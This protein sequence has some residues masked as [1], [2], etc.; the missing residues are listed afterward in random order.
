MITG[1][2]FP[3]NLLFSPERASVK[4]DDPG[5]ELDDKNDR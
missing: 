1:S 5:V 2:I 3:Y 4:A